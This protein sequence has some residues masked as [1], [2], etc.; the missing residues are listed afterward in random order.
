MTVRKRPARD[1]D[2]GRVKNRAVERKHDRLA[3]ATVRWR[4]RYEQADTSTAKLAA[5]YDWHRAAAQLAA[6]LVAVE[7]AELYLGSAHI[8]MAQ[9]AE[10]L[11]DKIAEML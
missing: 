4:A 7:L 11:C 3:A 1:R 10:E 9:N 8:G 6:Q 5:A 2:P